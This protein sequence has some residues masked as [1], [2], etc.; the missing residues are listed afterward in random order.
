MISI[1]R[2]TA[3]HTSRITCGE[4]FACEERIKTI[5]LE[6]PIALS[7]AAAHAIPGAISLGAIQHGI[8]FSSSPSQTAEAVV[9]FLVE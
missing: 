7:I 4:S 2:S 5:T 6:L 8:A 1:P 9:V 3:A